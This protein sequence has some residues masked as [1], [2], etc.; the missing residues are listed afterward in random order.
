[1]PV[2]DWTLV[3]AGIFHDLHKAWTAE[4]RKTLND[5][6]L[7]EGFLCPRR[8]TRRSVHHGR[9]DAARQSRAD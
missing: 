5:G 4:L 6:R 1:M 8:V 9:A 2:H 3:E 7:P